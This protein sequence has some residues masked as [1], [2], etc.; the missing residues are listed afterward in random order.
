MYPFLGQTVAQRECIICCEQRSGF[1]ARF[2]GSGHGESG[3]FSPLPPF[4]PLRTQRHV[5]HLDTFALHPRSPADNHSP[6]LMDKAV[7]SLGNNIDGFLG[8]DSIHLPNQTSAHS[9]FIPIC[10]GRHVQPRDVE[11]IP[12]GLTT[13]R[14]LMR[15]LPLHCTLPVAS[16]LL[17][18][19]TPFT[20]SRR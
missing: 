5:V 11:G 6:M 14:P 9:V 19:G 3:H 2:P 4:P 7:F 15:V 12:Q 10:K 16:L 8:N 17:Q 20:L 1:N 13:A 18:A